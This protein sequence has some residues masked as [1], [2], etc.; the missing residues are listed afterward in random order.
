MI[1]HFSPEIDRVPD[2]VHRGE[3]GKWYFWC[4]DCSGL[5]GP[6]LTEERARRELEIYVKHLG[7]SMERSDEK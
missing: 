2:P 7:I 3:D 5:E 6:F 4:E 1:S